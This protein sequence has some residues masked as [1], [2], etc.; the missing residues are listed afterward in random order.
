MNIPFRRYLIFLLGVGTILLISYVARRARKEKVGY[1]GPVLLLI[2]TMLALTAAY[3]TQRC[4]DP[5]AIVDAKQDEEGALFSL[6]Y[7]LQFWEFVVIAVINLLNAIA[8]DI[9]RRRLG[10]K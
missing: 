9:H 5:A 7:Q 6:L 2:N 3:I 1:R 4:V 10:V 8:S